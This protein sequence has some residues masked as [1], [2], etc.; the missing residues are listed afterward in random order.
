MRILNFNICRKNTYYS[1][2]AVLTIALLFACKKNNDVV[3]QQQPVISYK[4]KIVSL[5]EDMAMTP[6]KPDSLGGAITEYSVS[7]SLPK[8]IEINKLNGV[9]SGTPSDTLMPAK[10]VVKAT[11]PGGY[12]ND[13]LTLSVGTVAFNYGANATFTFEKGAT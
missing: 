9:I 6:L 7:P 8:G 2:L 1:V 11:G 13:T 12:A 4:Q 10:F 5:A 3:K